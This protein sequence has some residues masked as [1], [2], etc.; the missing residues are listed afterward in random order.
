MGARAWRK[1]QMRTVNVI[2]LVTQD[3]IEHNILHLLGRKQALADGVI[4]G[5][6]DPATLKM[7]S[8]RAAFVER[9]Q[10][11]MAAPARPAPR[12]R[13]PEE[14]VVADL[15]ERHGDKLLLADARTG[16]DGQP[17]LLVVLDLEPQALAAETARLSAVESVAVDVLDR[18]VW[19]AMQR[20]AA[21][22]LLHFTSQSRLLHRAAG[23]PGQQADAPAP[24][25]RAREL[26]AEAQRSLRM[27]RVLAAGGF[28]EDAPLLLAKVVQKAAAARMAERSELPA[29][30]S[31]ASDT[32]IRRLV[33]RGEFSV[34]ALAI[35]DA[36]HPSAG[37]PASDG[38][39]ALM[40]AAEQILSASQ[41]HATAAEPSRRAA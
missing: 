2:N 38:L 13:P 8:G 36:S 26:L 17:K 3:S 39:N 12:V 31:H 40:L 15:V 24:D 14:M 41:Q 37:T 1:N 25:Q 16:A 19:L 9:M 35:L 23:L 33:E 27:A 18:T 29:G 6:G 22:G 11:I 5:A 4:D 32:D 7:P 30:A 34:D 21:S 20:F 10:A 28:P